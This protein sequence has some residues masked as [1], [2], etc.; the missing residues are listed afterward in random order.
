M[1]KKENNRKPTDWIVRYSE[2]IPAQE[3]LREALCTLGNGYVASRGCACETKA[4]RVNYPGTYMAGLYNKTGTKMSGRVIYNEDLVN[5]PNWLLVTFKVDNGDWINPAK[6]TILSYAQELDIKRGILSYRWRIKDE[7]GKITSLDVKRIVHIINRHTLALSY[8]ITP[9]NYSGT[10]WLRSGLDGS[11]ENTGVA[12]Y[13]ELNTKHLFPRAMGRVKNEGIFLSVTTKP[14][15]IDIALSAAAR[16]FLGNKEIHDHPEVY[17]RGKNFIAQDF[18]VRVKQKQ[19]LLIEKTVSIFSSKKDDVKKP[20]AE[21]KKALAK[22][23]RFS[24]LLASHVKGWARLWDDFDMRIEGD[25]FSQHVLRL[26]AFHLL[27]SFS[28]HNRTLDAGITARGLHGE[29]YRG[30]IFWDELFVMPFYDL[31]MPDIAKALLLYRY[32]RLGPAR[33]AARENDYYGAMFPWQS[34]STGEEETQV[35][36]LNPVSGKWG[37]DYSCIQR[38]VSFAIAYNVW[39]Y[40]LRTHDRAFMR[41]CGV[42]LML[43]IARFGASLAQYDQKD[44]RYHTYNIMGPDEFHEKYPEASEPGLTDNA[45]TNFLIVW[46]LMRS[47]DALYTLS[48]AQRLR[49][50]KKLGLSQKEIRRWKDITRKMNIIINSDGIISQFKGYFALKELNW[51]AYRKKYENIHRMDRILKAEGKSPNAYKVAKQADVLQLFYLLPLSEIQDIFARLGY[52]FDAKMLSDNYEYYEARTSHGSTLSKVVHCYVALLLGREKEAWQWYQEV[53]RSDIKD[54]QGGTTPEGIHAGVM[55]SSL[56]IAMRGFAGIEFYEDT[57]TLDPKLPS[58]WRS[59]SFT[60]LFRKKRIK[61]TITKKTITLFVEGPAGQKYT[62][63][64]LVHGHAHML[65]CGKKY[66]VHRIEKKPPSRRAK[67]AEADQK[68][69][70]IVDGDILS[71]SMLETRLEALGHQVESVRLG[72]EALDIIEREWVD[73]IILSISLQGDMNGLQLL[74]QIRAHKKYKNIP[75]VVLSYKHGMEAL[76]KGYSIQ[77]Y[78]KKPTQLQALMPGIKRILEKQ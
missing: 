10:I 49:L 40:W 72:A 27:Q 37:P 15:A 66:V 50:Q 61:I 65:T 13:R 53:L 42:E 77:G 8:S 45:Y 58:A 57:I 23:N 78:Y 70:L 17:K 3:G 12:R 35:M 69:V 2:Y 4:S 76:I 16:V 54:T 7:T 9:E 44:E 59:F 33:R 60:V 19:T 22:K 68:R 24:R 62:Y 26:H 34:G 38:H 41:A 11:V 39:Q 74:R 56:S 73:L 6:E 30:H 63:P 67:V 36:H 1:S 51:N 48:P 14:G 31:H 46:V 71:S 21:A 28:P 5:C 52:A 47:H 25:D 75:V 20:L 29:A 43:S 64:V 55:A 32:R 18:C